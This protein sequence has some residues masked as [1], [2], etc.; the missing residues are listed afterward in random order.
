MV[1]N[2]RL[3]VRLVTGPGSGS[4]SN[5]LGVKL[6]P[7]AP[8]KYRKGPEPERWVSKEDEIPSLSNGA[9]PW[10]PAWWLIFSSCRQGATP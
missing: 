8:E 1:D 5:S 7:P 4:G 6:A 9:V 2:E 3:L 10:G